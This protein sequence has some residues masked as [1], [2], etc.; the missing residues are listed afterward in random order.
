M[1]IW[2]EL[3][4]VL[5]PSHVYVPG[6]TPRHPEGWF[7]D[8]KSNVDPVNSPAALHQTQAF[9]A[10]LA[11]LGAGYFW[12]CHEVLEAVWMRTADPSAERDVVQALIQLANA[13][14]KLLMGRHRAAH[15]LCDIVQ[16]HLARCPD[17]MPVLGLRIDL[18]QSEL[19]ATRSVVLMHY[20]A[21]N[22]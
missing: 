13:R 20:K 2:P 18:L 8:I 3:S 6:K 1:S 19:Q 10:G 16:A 12:E 21:L 17:D 5:R 22:G 7:D 9:Q 14:L 15:R 11:Y 4:E